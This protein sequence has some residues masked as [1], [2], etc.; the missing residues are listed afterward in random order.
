MAYPTD[1]TRKVRYV[2]QDVQVLDITEYVSIINS[3]KNSKFVI[4][5]EFSVFLR[6]LGKTI[7]TMTFDHSGNTTL[8]PVLLANENHAVLAQNISTL[9]LS[10]FVKSRIEKKDENTKIVRFK[11]AVTFLQSKTTL[12]PQ[13]LNRSVYGVRITK[14]ESGEDIITFQKDVAIFGML[15]MIDGESLKVMIDETDDNVVQSF[16]DFGLKCVARERC[17]NTSNIGYPVWHP[18][19]KFSNDNS[20]MN[21]VIESFAPSTKCFKQLTTGFSFS[22]TGI[23]KDMFTR[24]DCAWLISLNPEIE[25]FTNMFS[26]AWTIIQSFSDVIEFNVHCDTTGEIGEF[27]SIYQ[28]MTR[29][30]EGKRIPQTQTNFMTREMLEKN[31]LMETNKA[32]FVITSVKILQS[33]A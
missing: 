27:T 28:Q 32:E 10:E 16:D 15:E 31:S 20:I 17:E 23:S 7:F 25:I 26:P 21:S 1:V 5:N 8:L 19:S 29:S 14:D 12:P 30:L 4:A 9:S 33:D 13:M 3:T 22:E 11:L 18:S 2:N 24:P 6:L